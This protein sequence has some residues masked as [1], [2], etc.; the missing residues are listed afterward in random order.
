MFGDSVGGN[1]HL[2]ATGSNSSLFGDVSEIMGGS[3]QGGDDYLHNQAAGSPPGRRRPL[4]WTTRPRAA[5]TC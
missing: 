5:T 4:A 2:R 1:D 3:S